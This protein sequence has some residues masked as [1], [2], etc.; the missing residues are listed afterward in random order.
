VISQTEKE[1]KLSQS[2]KYKDEAG[3]TC[4]DTPKTA[5]EQRVTWPLKMNLGNDWKAL[6]MSKVEVQPV[7]L[8]W[9]LSN[10]VLDSWSPTTLKY[11]LLALVSQNNTRFDSI[12]MYISAEYVIIRS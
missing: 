8:T 2:L 1:F 10:L 11:R 4:V 6:A 5:R 7:T 3:F 12:Y 9:R